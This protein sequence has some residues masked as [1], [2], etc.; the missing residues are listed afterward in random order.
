[1][2]EAVGMWSRAV[3]L[4]QDDVVPVELLRVAVELG[5]RVPRRWSS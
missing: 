2:V 4:S 1:M 5:W 3:E